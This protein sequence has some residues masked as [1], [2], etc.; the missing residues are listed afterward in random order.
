VAIAGAGDVGR[1]IANAVLEAGKG[2]HKVLLIERH[3][4]H[5]RPDL[6]PSADWMLA[7]ACELAA[8]Q[9]AGIETAD[10]VIAATGDD[11]VNLVFAMLCKTE[12]AL[13]RVV[14]R[15]NNPDNHWLF[16]ASWGVDVAVSTTNT[17]VA[18]VEEEV[19]LSGVVAMMTL[20]RG[21]GTIL[22]TRLPETSRLIGRPLAELDLPPGTAL[23]AVCRD[24]A[25]VNPSAELILKPR[26]QIVLLAGADIE[27][28]TRARLETALER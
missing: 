10:V 18:V 14:A 4:P 21:H 12:F 8:L 25:V 3:R 27:A 13:K 6:A 17:V 16:N 28:Q 5:Y 24:S 15:V 9:A 2:A 19:T 20:P 1:S 11:K 7:D 22:E 23:L 26:D